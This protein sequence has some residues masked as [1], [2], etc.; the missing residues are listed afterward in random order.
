MIGEGVSV[1]AALLAGGITALLPCTYPMSIGYIALLMGEGGKEKSVFRALGM[2]VRFFIGF[3]AVYLLFGAAAGLFGHFSGPALAIHGLRPVL[4]TVGALFFIIVGLIYLGAV[5]L[6]ERLKQIR[7]IRMPK[8]LSAH[9][10]WGTPVI[11]AIFAAAW[12]PCIGPVLGGILVLAAGSG[13]V[14]HGS[15]LMTAFAVG[16][17]VPFAALTV[18]YV[19][20]SRFIIRADAVTG[21]MRLLAGFLF[22]ALGIAFLTGN[23]LFSGEIYPSGF[24]ERYI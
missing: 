20:T 11:G 13:S 21:I 17:M 8:T 5:P 19:K 12:S 7:M 4:T 9:A 10:W 22:I 15:L 2:T 23:T 18:L 24:L 16:M 1:S 3:T 14:F 6:P